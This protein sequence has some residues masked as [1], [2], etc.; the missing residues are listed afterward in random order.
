MDLGPELAEELSME[1]IEIEKVKKVK[2][3]LE[4]K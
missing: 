4:Q 1:K 3:I 2:P